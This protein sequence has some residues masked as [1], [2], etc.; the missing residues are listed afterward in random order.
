MTAVPSTPPALPVGTVTFL[1]TDVEGSM[2]LAHRLR[3]RWDPLNAAHLDVIREAVAVHGGSVVRTEGDAVFAAFGEAGAAV[4]AAVAAQRRLVETFAGGAETPLYVR[5]GLHSGEAHRSGDDYG[6]FEVNRAARVAAAGHGGQVILSEAT[7]ALVHD[8]LPP[9]TR[10][11]DLGRHVL[12]D[13][14]RAERISQLDIEGLPT[15]FPPLRTVGSGTGNLPQRLTSLI[16]RDADLEALERVA[17][18]ARLVTLTGP[19]GIGKSSL[20]VELARR[21]APTAPDG[22][23]FV[24]LETLDD[25]GLVLGAIART[26]GL[27]DG[28]DRSAAEA[29][30]A[31]L[32]ER[33]TIFVLDNFEHVLGAASSIPDLLQAAPA[34]RVIATSRAPLRVRGEREVPIR[35]LDTDAH[36]APA[37]RLFLERARSIRPDFAA[38]GEEAGV[39]REI[40]GLLDGLPLGVELAAARVGALPVTLIRD[41]LAR[42]LPLPGT[43][44]RDGPERQ[45]T[46]DGAVGWSHDLLDARTRA[47]L[48]ALAVFEGG[49]D[50]EQASQV[51]APDGDPDPDLLEDLVQLADHS[52]IV[53]TAGHPGPRYRMLRTIQSFALARLGESGRE[54]DVRR[55]HAAAFRGLTA[56]AREGLSSADQAMWIDRLSADDANLRTALEWAINA[57]EAEVAQTLVGSLWQYWRTTGQLNATAALADAALAMPGGQDP[58]PARMWAV[59]A[60]GNIAYWRAESHEAKQDYTE[61]E[62]LARILGDEAGLADAVFNLGHVAFI[63][64]ADEE[65]LKHYVAAA[66]ARYRD[67]GDDR[68]AARARWAYGTLAIS[69]G[70]LDEAESFFGTALEDFRRNGDVQYLAMTEGSLGWLGMMR[71][72]IREAA[73]W[74]V[75]S[76]AT[77]YAMRDVATS[78][79]SLHVGVLLAVLL[80][81]MDDAVRMTGAFEALCDRYGVRPPAALGRFVTQLDPFARARAGVAPEDYDR[82]H[83]EGRRMTLDQAVALL[84]DLGELAATLPAEPGIPD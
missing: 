32:G 84:T 17:R 77:T 70:R 62:R 52:L 79:I 41:R 51:A 73:A 59:A 7:T 80:G 57:G 33:S 28:G 29:L 18:D 68:G 34:L 37:Q 43:G 20:A 82:L 78:T 48:Q 54:A 1:R 64:G 42:R 3:D 25:A 22:V 13:V 44:P 8:R 38:T 2:A 76:T 4:G 58:T 10:L 21:L 47:I 74:S 83:G 71:G 75:R 36:D 30:P 26:V 46:L 49:F 50:L 65:Q 72:T 55:R 16:G 53:P 69:A 23:W 24:A 5:M 31:F 81:R 35:P 63:D 15:D 19:G 56:A 45:R 39:V 66:E 6:G 12:R 14:P 27:F 11:R 61:Q 40:C 67:L 9:G 60:R